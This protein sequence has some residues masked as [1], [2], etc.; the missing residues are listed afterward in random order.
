MDP[1]RRRPLVVRVGRLDEEDL[2]HGGGAGDLGGGAARNS[3]ARR[4]V[5]PD[6]APAGRRAAEPARV[7]GRVPRVRHRARADLDRDVRRDRGPRPM[8]TLVG[9]ADRLS[10]LAGEEIGFKVSCRAPTY[11]ADIV[12]LVH[13]D[14]NPAGP[15][16]KEELLETSV[17]GEYRGRVQPIRPGSYAIVPGGPLLRLQG[18]F[19][20]H[21]WVYP[22]M[23]AKGMQGLV[24]RWSGSRG[25]G[26]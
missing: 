4:L 11:H 16:F 8:T 18:S 26:L 7:P 21:A 3:R 12:R 5:H 17:S 13:G 1:G 22:T 23:P 6:D 9:Y 19:T 24:T 15:G 10:V 20:V 2:D 14:E 25:W